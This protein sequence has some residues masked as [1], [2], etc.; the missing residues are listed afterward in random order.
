MNSD[1]KTVN[2]EEI[3]LVVTKGT[4]PT[5]VGFSFIDDGI[6]YVKSESISFTGQINASKFAFIS[7]D[8]HSALS[9]CRC[10]RCFPATGLPG[11]CQYS[12]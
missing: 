4:T 9:S 5:T 10:C 3:A 12:F 2:I 1:W 6:N 11:G 7:Q 8:A